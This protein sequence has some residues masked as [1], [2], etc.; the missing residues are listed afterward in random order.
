MAQKGSVHG[1]DDRFAALEPSLRRIWDEAR[2]AW[3][4]VS[5][6]HARFVTYLTERIP[7]GADQGKAIV[8]TH[9]ADLY[10]ACACT[11][12][13]PAALLAFERRYLPQV[14]AHL[15][16]QN[17]L[18]DFTDEVKQMLRSRLLVA[19]EGAAPR[20]AGYSG[21]GPLAAW[22]RVAAV[23]AAI[24][25]RRTQA[26]VGERAAAETLEVSASVDP[27]LALLRARY[28]EAVREAIAAALRALEPREATVLRLFFLQGVT[29]E[30]IG[31]LYRTSKRTARRWIADARTKILDE[32][33]R[34]LAERYDA[35]TTQLDSLIR[36]V[37]ADLEPSIVKLLDSSEDS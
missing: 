30:A 3:P 16:R 19:E 37:H 13:D 10:L 17:L 34:R 28:G 20:I 5:L 15:R 6:P 24:D 29:T 12:G 22:L 27:E 25:L 7:E 2:A 35:S 18:P 36:V 31:A 33:R 4:G 1:R 14:E 9:A 26:G 11:T 8:E 21:R 32:T 23:R